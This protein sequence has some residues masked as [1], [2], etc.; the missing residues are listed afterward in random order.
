MQC[1]G[2][3]FIMKFLPTVPRPT[4]LEPA[5]FSDT[6]T[7]LDRFGEFRRTISSPRGLMFFLR[8]DSKKIFNG[9]RFVLYA[10]VAGVGSDGKAYVDFAEISV[11]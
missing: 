10:S 1:L 6:I 5:F 9:N 8:R 7:I 11:A 3:I 4:A 2:R